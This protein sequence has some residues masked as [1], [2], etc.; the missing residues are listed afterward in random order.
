[1]ADAVLSD[2]ARLQKGQYFWKEMATVMRTWQAEIRQQL[3]VMCNHA[4]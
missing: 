1:M 3:L 2:P 4:E